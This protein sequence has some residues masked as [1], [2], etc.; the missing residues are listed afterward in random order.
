[1]S[2]PYDDHSC[3]TPHPR[4]TM[5]SCLAVL[6]I[7]KQHTQ[8]GLMDTASSHSELSAFESGLIMHLRTVRHRTR[9]P[10][11]RMMRPCM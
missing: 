5:A 9:R 4:V 7:E 10:W 1:M 11:A 3:T 2:R 8:W 6:I